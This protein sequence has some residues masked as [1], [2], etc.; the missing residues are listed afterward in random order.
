MLNLSS[1]EPPASHFPSVERD[2]AWMTRVVT[3]PLNISDWFATN[4]PAGL[5]GRTSLVSCQQEKKLQRTIS[6]T[7]CSA[8]NR[9]AK[10]LKRQVSSD[11]LVKY[12]NSGMGSPTEC[13]TLSSSESL[14]NNVGG[15]SRSDILQETGDI[16]PQYYLSPKHLVTTL[17]EALMKRGAYLLSLQRQQEIPTREVLAWL[18]AIAPE[19]IT[20]EWKV[21]GRERVRLMKRKGGKGSAEITLPSLEP[22]T[23]TDTKPSETPS[24][25]LS[26][27][28]SEKESKSLIASQ[29]N[30]MSTRTLKIKTCEKCGQ[31]YKKDRDYKHRDG[32][33]VTVSAAVSAPSVAD[34]Q[35]AV[36]LLKSLD[37]PIYKFFWNQND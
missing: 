29:E 14:S 1:A 5:S 8:R 30:E 22:R 31:T 9:N 21:G 32:R 7:K 36:K 2:L 10:S 20:K 19:Q 3:S 33:C 23:R 37:E 34:I 15:C 18:K 4:V 27:A 25:F 26:C 13:W 6:I 16:P 24:P 11:S 28:G 17:R 35:F 12:K